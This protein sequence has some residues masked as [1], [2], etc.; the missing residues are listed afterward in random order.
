MGEPGWRMG[1]ACTKPPVLCAPDPTALLPTSCICPCA[2]L[3]D[4]PQIRPWAQG[5]QAGRQHWLTERQE[6]GCRRCRRPQG[7]WAEALYLHL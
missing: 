3:G 1:S 2:R 6:A 5:S 4:M 7:A